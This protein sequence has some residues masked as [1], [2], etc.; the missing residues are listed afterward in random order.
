M[1][2]AFIAVAVFSLTCALAI[3]EPPKV[4]TP[5]PGT[6]E[7][8]ALSGPR[9]NIAHAWNV[10]VRDEKAFQTLWAE[11]ANH[12]DGKVPPMPKVDFKKMDVIAVFLGLLPT[13]GQSAEIGE[14]RRKGGI[15]V[16]R[17]M[18]LMPAG[19]GIAV[20]RSLTTPFAIK[21]VAKLPQ[22][23]TFEVTTVM[24]K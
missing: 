19:P 18:H 9:S 14:I 21:A 15:A 20:S 7:P 17:V 4:S 13:G 5:M 23:V 11:H 10:V 22:T 3:A 2:I 8:F 24:R 6:S 1:Q 16:V 12:H